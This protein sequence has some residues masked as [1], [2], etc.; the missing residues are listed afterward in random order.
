M[1]ICVTIIEGGWSLY[2]QSNDKYLSVPTVVDN[3]IVIYTHTQ[4]KRE[5]KLSFHVY[6]CV[7]L[8][9]RKKLSGG[10]RVALVNIAQ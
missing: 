10:T 9:R 5:R 3:A 1:R 4:K 7:E 2:T 6:I 8:R